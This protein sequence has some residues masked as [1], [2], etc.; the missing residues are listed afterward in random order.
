MNASKF[1][2]TL[3]I[4]G[5][6]ACGQAGAALLVLDFNADGLGGSIQA[7]QMIDDEYGAFGITITADNARAGHPDQAIAFDSANPTGGDSDLQTPVTGNVVGVD[8]NPLGNLLIIAEDIVDSEAD[9]IVDDPDDEARGG[10]IFFD[11]ELLQNT[12][13]SIV[14][15]DIEEKNGSVQFYKDGGLVDSITIPN[16]S[17][18][19]VQK[20]TWDEVEFDQLRVNFTGSGAVG[21][22]ELTNFIPEPASFALVALG[23]LA[24]LR[25]RSR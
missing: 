16:L 15:V 8:N 12:A 24:V 3:C 18:N 17:N 21:P 6:L 4:L 14:L 19:S 1:L 22:V 5:G 7:G 2:M 25:R 11:F 20:L 10:T 13:G 23:G 9:S